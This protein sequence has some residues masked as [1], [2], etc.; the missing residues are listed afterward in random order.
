MESINKHPVGEKR[1]QRLEKARLFMD[2]YQRAVNG[3][4][5]PKRIREI[6][7]ELDEMDDFGNPF[8]GYQVAMAYLDGGDRENYLKK[9]HLL[10]N[11]DC[12]PAM[13]TAGL[14]LI[15]QGKDFEG[16]MYLEKA[17]DWGYHQAA[18]VYFSYLSKHSKPPLSFWYYLRRVVSGIR[19]LTSG[20][21]KIDSDGNFTIT[22][23]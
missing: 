23:K 18:A 8:Y 5:P 6:A 7:I 1:K 12:L 22:L 10:A 13:C 16:L 21:L 9:I 11:R 14:D 2:K 4:L 15:H 17:K 3:D 19:T 20:Q